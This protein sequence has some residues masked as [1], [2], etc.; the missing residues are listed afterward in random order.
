VSICL[1]II[2][3]VPS[4][5]KT[6]FVAAYILLMVSNWSSWSDRP[7]IRGDFM[8]DPNLLLSTNILLMVV[9]DLF[10]VIVGL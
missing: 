9:L 8:V 3:V 1:F 2:F 4:C 6:S 5:K 7:F 10:W